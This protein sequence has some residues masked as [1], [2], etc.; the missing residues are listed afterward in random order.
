MTEIS[1]L[2][3]AIMLGSAICYAIAVLQLV[4]SVTGNNHAA[5]ASSGANTGSGIPLWGALGAALH[6]IS[7]AITATENQG[8][9]S[10]FF[11]A[12][13][14]TAFIVVTM[15][16]IAQ[17]RYPIRALLI[18]VFIIAGLCLSLANL[19]GHHSPIVASSKGMLTH[20]LSS[21]IAYSLLSLATVH[22]LALQVMERGLKDHSSGS[23]LKQLPPL[24]TMETLL[25]QLIGLGWLILSIAI[26]SG[27]IYVDD[28]LA[29]HLVHK[30]VFSIVSWILFALL[31]FGRQRY[32]W[33]G[34]TAV[35]W[36]LSAFIALALAYFGSKFVLEVLLHRQ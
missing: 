6:L 35:K 21:I 23:W 33:R 13:S 5:G 36:T 31:L 9:S 25:F 8:L 7:I 24:Q 12:L 16:L 27:G 14:I 30:T 18:P 11:D 10:S 32:G 17:T 15:S 2:S 1:P 26:V 28:V 29:Q 20:I 4:K 19:Y 3:L 34:A 22:A